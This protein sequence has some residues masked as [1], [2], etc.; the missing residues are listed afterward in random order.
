[1][2]KSDSRRPAVTALSA[3]LLVRFHGLFPGWSADVLGLINR[4]LPAPPPRRA[5][6]GQAIAKESRVSAQGPAVV[7]GRA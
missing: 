2:P 4:A 7:S 6:A 1:M 3:N 5:A